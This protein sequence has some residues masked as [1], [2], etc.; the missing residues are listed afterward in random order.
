[1]KTD[2]MANWIWPDQGPV[3]LN[4][5]LSSEIFDSDIAFN[6]TLVRE[7]IQNTL[8]AHLDKSKPVKIRFKFGSSKHNKNY[9]IISELFDLRENTDLADPE[10]WKNNQSISWLTVEDFNTTGL[11][12]DLT[13]RMGDF[14]NYWMNFNVSNKSGTRGGRGIGRV[15]FLIASGIKT[16]IGYT[17]RESDGLIASCGMAMLQP[18]KIGDQ[19][20][21]N[22]AYLAKALNN[23]IYDLHSSEHYN[24]ALKKAFDLEGYSGEESSGLAL[25]I[26]FP[27]EELTRDGILVSAIEH[28]APAILSGQLNVEVEDEDLN[29]ESI[30][31][32]ARRLNKDFNEDSI[33]QEPK[34]YIS[35]INKAFETKGKTISF[36][37]TKNAEFREYRKLNSKKLQKQLSANGPICLNIEFPLFKDGEE[38]LVTVK[39]VV[40]YAPANL[41]PLDHFFREGM[42]LPYVGANSPSDIDVILLADDENLSPY[43]NLCE[44]GAH[45]ELLESKD[46]K[47]KLALGNYK[48]NFSEKRF[49]K[50]LPQELRYLF[51]PEITEPDKNT[52]K[53]YFSIKKPQPEKKKKPK[54]DIDPP[55][56]PPPPPPPPPKPNPSVVIAETLSDGFEVKPN[57]KYGK[58][59]ADI[60]IT[61]SYADGSRNPKWSRYDFELDK[62]DITSEAC[63]VKLKGNVIT[64]SGFSNNSSLIVSGFDTNRELDTR[65]NRIR[66]K[67]DA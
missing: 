18:V 17:R 7:A 44:G 45:L 24:A 65:F 63:K 12:G 41:K 51:I 15:T 29:K 1:M 28:F 57:P 52:F 20:K 58:Y 62:L 55:P 39:A 40:G 64:A 46:V 5:S 25:V 61:I 27:H 23:Q 37:T 13:D 33:K 19:L 32:I 53:S 36:K 66:S 14:W 8:D 54:P 6:E 2:N 22:Y 21:S 48:T 11:K 67:S 50:K 43:L 38:K 35:L 16:V 3:A 10:E 49:V 30:E 4:N 42:L 9:G 26:P 56:V 47:E 34:R 60:H 31:F 59:P